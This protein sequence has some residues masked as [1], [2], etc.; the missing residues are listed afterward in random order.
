MWTRILLV[1]IGEKVNLR[2]TLLLPVTLP[3]GIVTQLLPFQYCTSKASSPYNEKLS[4]RRTIGPYS[5]HRGPQK[6]IWSSHGRDELHFVV[7]FMR[8]TIP[9]RL[10]TLR[11]FFRPAL[12][13][14][15]NVTI[16]ERSKAL[17]YFREPQFFQLAEPPTAT[18]L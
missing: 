5:E 4:S 14:P 3:P 1:V 11:R 6:L 10:E 13:K 17:F 18:S 2:Q 16:I 9:P 8:E 15:L 7:V 12:E